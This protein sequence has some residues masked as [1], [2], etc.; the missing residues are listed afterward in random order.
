MFLTNKRCAYNL[1][2]YRYIINKMSIDKEKLIKDYLQIQHAL[3]QASE[4]KK[5]LDVKLKDIAE[6][7]EKYMIDNQEQEL[8]WD[9]E[10]SA[11]IERYG[12]PGKVARIS[13]KSYSSLGT[14]K[15]LKQQI[16]RYFEIV[17][18]ED[19]K[20]AENRALKCVEW[21]LANRTQNEVF[22]LKRYTFDELKR[23][24]SKKRKT[25]TMS[26]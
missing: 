8:F 10:D 4:R 25:D 22:Y 6:S 1:Y 18:E 7:L 23:K 13:R 14:Q 11:E 21:L 2:T 9:T 24:S 20:C 15:Y 19:S 17:Y 16:Q 3:L 26:D 5:S 12:Q